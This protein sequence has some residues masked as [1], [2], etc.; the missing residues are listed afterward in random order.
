ESFGLIDQGT[1]SWF[2][3]Q[4]AGRDRGVRRPNGNG[5]MYVDKDGKP[6]EDGSKGNKVYHTL[7]VYLVRKNG[8][9]AEEKA[10]IKKSSGEFLEEFFNPIDKQARRDMLYTNLADLLD[11]K[12]AEF[13]SE[14]MANENENGQQIIFEFIQR[15]QTAMGSSSNLALG[16]SA[17]SGAEALNEKKKQFTAFL[18][19][20][21]DNDSRFKALSKSSQDAIRDEINALKSQ[22][23]SFAERPRAPPAMDSISIVL[24]RGVSGAVKVMNTNVAR[25]ELPEIAPMAGAAQ[26]TAVKRT[27]KAVER[28]LKQAG[29]DVDAAK[30]REDLYNS[31]TRRWTQKGA[32]AAE[33][34]NQIKKSKLTRL[35]SIIL[36]ALLGGLKGKPG[37]DKLLNITLALMDKGYLSSVSNNFES[38][39]IK[40]EY[41]SGLMN[42][43][44]NVW[45]GIQRIVNADYLR[46]DILKDEE[47]GNAMMATASDIDMAKVVLRHISHFTQ[48]YAA[49]KGIL[50]IRRINYSREV[51]EFRSLYGKEA[52]LGLPM[53]M[54]S[55]L[56]VSVLSGSP[57]GPVLYG[58][59]GGGVL[60]YLSIGISKAFDR[61]KIMYY[62]AAA[63]RSERNITSTM[64]AMLRDTTDTQS[65]NSVRFMFKLLHPNLSYGFINTKV[66]NYIALRKVMEAT[67]FSNKMLRGLD[68]ADDAK[69]EAALNL[70]MAFVVNPGNRK[71]K[72]L[73]DM[74]EAV[75]SGKAVMKPGVNT[76]TVFSAML[77]LLKHREKIGLKDLERLN[78]FLG[79]TSRNPVDNYAYF[80]PGIS[81]EAL[82][83]L[84]K[85]Y[86]QGYFSELGISGT[87]P[88]DKAYELLGKSPIEALNYLIKEFIWGK[89]VIGLFGAGLDIRDLLDTST[90]KYKENNSLK[91]MFDEIEKATGRKWEPGSPITLQMIEKIIAMNVKSTDYKT[92][93]EWK[94]AINSVRHIVYMFYLGPAATKQ[95]VERVK[96]NYEA[97]RDINPEWADAYDVKT[98]ANKEMMDKIFGL[99]NAFK[100]KDPEFAKW[101]L[102]LNPEKAEAMPPQLA[103]MLAQI[104][105]NDPERAKQIEEQ[106]NQRAR[107]SEGLP[108]R[109]LGLS[110]LGGHLTGRYSNMVTKALNEFMKL[111][112]G[113]SNEEKLRI[114]VDFTKDEKLGPKKMAM[115]MENA[116]GMYDF[117]VTVEG[118]DKEFV[119]SVVLD[120]SR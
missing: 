62:G 25:S 59:V 66:N 21:A 100:D 39:K 97:M 33:Y 7:T 48:E 70:A 58:M 91:K 92:E 69:V 18:E 93:K 106:L 94:D 19:N 103:Q 114:L 34:A 45:H 79:Y 83:T 3:R 8:F 81:D 65:A 5:F 36:A 109:A 67:G 54:K 84:R 31:R 52:W 29:V 64:T 74:V 107:Q 44:L 15:Y 53:R 17:K 110:N 50:N 6:T 82:K 118:M 12:G 68:L 32:L 117:L 95:D 51:A 14:L 23:L 72:K 78:S 55:P 9:S 86:Y 115:R 27:A 77:K 71:Y 43:K 85:M 112:E 104:K 24:S 60:P 47:F 108:T 76:A 105:A 30:Q 96:E 89:G 98:L 49:L 4:L 99:Y 38:F 28:N 11:V 101:L 22:E 80:R 46:K 102:E 120:P 26:A 119:M 37:E 13:L 42:R 111:L 57:L 40:L 116:K 113:K 87:V 10:A 73:E 41:I 56:I 20:F 90:G 61:L 1:T 16:T 2:F 88:L 35:I 63:Y 75:N